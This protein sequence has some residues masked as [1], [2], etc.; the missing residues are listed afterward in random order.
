MYILAVALQDG[1][2][3]HVRSYAPERAN[4]EDTVRL[5][6]KISTIEDTVW[7]E[8]YHD[9]DPDK[10][11]FGGLLELKLASCETVTDEVAVANA[12]PS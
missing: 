3:H 1:E 8:R 11:A 4:R 9:P 10:R 2:W 12:P 7:T 6:G 5:W